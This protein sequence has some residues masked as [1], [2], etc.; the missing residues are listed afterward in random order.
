MSTTALR[1]EPNK[2][3]FFTLSSKEVGRGIWPVYNLFEVS[4]LSLC[5]R[6]QM[7]AYI[8]KDHLQFH[9][10]LTT[11]PKVV[12]HLPAR[13]GKLKSDK[14]A[15]AAVVRVIPSEAEASWCT[16]CTTWCHNLTTHFT[17]CSRRAAPLEKKV[18]N[19][20]NRDSVWKSQLL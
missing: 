9:R 7:N 2:P 18:E 3:G 19:R 4:L 1:G 20:I 11:F 13:E 14:S 15:S 6:R 10:S 17:F 16:Q 12:L 5:K 8:T